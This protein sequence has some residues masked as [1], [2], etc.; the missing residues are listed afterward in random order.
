MA[1]RKKSIRKNSAKASTRPAQAGVKSAP[2]GSSK[3]IVWILI[4]VVVVIFAVESTNLFHGE[5]VKDFPVQSVL[6]ITNHNKCGDFNAWGIT[7]VGKDRIMVVDQGHNRVLLFDRQ[8]NC[9]KDWG[10]GG[11][12]PMEFN[13]PSGITSDDK[14]NGYV[15]DTWNSA[16]KGFDENGKEILVAHLS[17]GN[18]YGPR[19]IGFDGH[20]FV[21]ADTG[22]HRVALVDM[23]G[24][25]LTTWGASGKEPGQYHGLL[26]AVSDEKG[27]YFIADSENDRVQ[28]LDQDGKVVK[29]FKCRAGVASV[30]LDKE[31]RLYV[32]TGTGNGSS[33]VKAYSLKDGYLGDLKD[34]KGNLVQGDRGMAVTQDDVLMIAGGGQVAFYKLPPAHP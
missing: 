8:G 4:A 20:N 29:I 19:G 11:K 10:K 14:G 22:S 25:L 5:V 12:G 1:P 6:M 27:D 26:D 13:E 15:I 16:I 34:E 24:K 3:N 17:N 33:C 23:D 28:W 30:A 18:F 9:L 21:V 2:A 31:G 32:S 7:P